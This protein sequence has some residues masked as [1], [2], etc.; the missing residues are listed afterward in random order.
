MFP[1]NTQTPTPGST[2]A[3]PASTTPEYLTKEEFSR[4]AACTRGLSEKL[5][6]L[7]KAVPTMDTFVSLGLLEKAEDGSFKPKAAAAPAAPTKTEPNTLVADMEARFR[8]ELKTRDDALIDERRKSADTAQR[9]AVG[10]ALNKAGAVNAGRDVIHVSGI[11]KNAAGEYVQTVKDEFGAA[12][13]ITLDEAANIFLKANP[14][15]KRAS[16]IPGSGTP[17]GSTFS[18]GTQIVSR[19][20]M[21]DPAWYAKNREGVM[22][23]A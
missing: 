5:D 9:S 17:A 18:P 22:S 11:V 8:A 3:A 2:P 7:V 6:G 14:E 13:E 1:P 23:G 4:S 15:L 21:S 20:Q 16:G 10:E 19:A 12:K